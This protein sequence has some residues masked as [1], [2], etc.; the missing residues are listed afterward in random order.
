M[1]LSV[2]V[3]ALADLLE[4][5]TEGVRGMR[6][7]F[8]AVSEALASRKLPQFEEPTSVKYWSV[9]GYGYSGLHAL[10]EVAALCW[11]NRPIPRDK[12]IDG[13]SFPTETALFEKALEHLKAPNVWGR[14]FKR[15]QKLPFMHLIVH[16][17]S[18]GYYIPVDFTVPIVPT[19]FRE[20]SKHIWPVGSVQQ[21][22]REVELLADTLAVPDDL[23][24]SDPRIHDCLDGKRAEDPAA[25]WALQPIAC[26]SILILREACEVSI[27]CGAAIHFE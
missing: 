25:L 16:P 17:D 15:K 26:Y 7:E 23:R 1:G 22:Q 27:E 9:D 13:H 14:L 24:S 10:R 8:E 21:L 6:Q 11:K 20:E 4:N 3:G 18:A 19:I 2:T 5:N 12:V